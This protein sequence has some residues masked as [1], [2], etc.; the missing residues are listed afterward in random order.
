MY[1]F[2]E[3]EREGSEVSSDLGDRVGEQLADYTDLPMLA[4]GG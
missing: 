3:C 2:L 4:L 1:P